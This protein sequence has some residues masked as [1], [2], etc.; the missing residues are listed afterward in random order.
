MYNFSYSWNTKKNFNSIENKPGKLKTEN[1]Y[2]K[3]LLRCAKCKNKLLVVKEL[4]NEY[5][6]KLL[7]NITEVSKNDYYIRLKR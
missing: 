6:L 1:E 3:K 7:C 4:K 5:S 2:L